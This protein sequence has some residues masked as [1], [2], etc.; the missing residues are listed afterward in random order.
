[1]AIAL[2]LL[3]IMG[4]VKIKSN[5]SCNKGSNIVLR[6][7]YLYNK[8]EVTTPMRLALEKE[9]LAKTG[10]LFI[11]RRKKKKISKK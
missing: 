8:E 5:S 6:E 3:Q 11:R 7:K 2:S 4:K 1:M 9:L 10:P